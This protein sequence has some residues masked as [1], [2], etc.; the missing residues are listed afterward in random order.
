MAHPCL[1]YVKFL[2]VTGRDSGT[3]SAASIDATLKDLEFPSL[4]VNEYDRIRNSFKIPPKLMLCNREHEPT[5]KFMRDEKIYS[6]WDPTSVDKEIFEFIT[7][8]Q[9]RETAQIL[10]MGGIDFVRVAEVVTVKHRMTKQLNARTI[11]LL[12]H[13]F[14]NTTHTG[15]NAWTKY[16][17]G[18]TRGDLFIGALNGEKD[19]Y[20]KA[21]I[22]GEY[23]PNGKDALRYAF[24]SCHYRMR[25]SRVLPTCKDSADIVTKISK[26]LKALYE[27][28]YGE[29]EDLKNIIKELQAFKLPSNE[30]KTRAILDI[31]NAGGSFSGAGGKQNDKVNVD[32]R[33]GEVGTGNG[34][35][36]GGEP[37]ALEG[38]RSE[39]C[40]VQ[41]DS[42]LLDPVRR[43]DSKGK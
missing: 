12:H 34:S 24:S 10:L 26:E 16:L 17:W 7:L 33:A 27:S 6:L 42:E 20:F 18:W 28:I 13:Y 29:G 4:E 25:A 21:D 3:D 2:M 36:D 32:N 30:R 43:M 41:S 35:E 15:L 39:S 40:G 19:A 1:Y 9:P 14:W 8:A 23:D 37:K 38:C 22:D 5:A 11:E 31:V